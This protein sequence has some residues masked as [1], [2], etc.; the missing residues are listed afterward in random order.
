MDKVIT[1]SEEIEVLPHRFIDEHIEMLLF[2]LEKSHA[3]NK[4]KLELT[5]PAYL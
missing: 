3:A 2:K 4:M 5:S 1:K